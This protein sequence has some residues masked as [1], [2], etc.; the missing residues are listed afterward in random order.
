MTITIYSENMLPTD[1][2]EYELLTE[3]AEMAAGIVGMGCEI[4]LRRG[5]GSRMIMDSFIKKGEFKTHVMVD[6][7]GDIEYLTTEKNQT[8]LYTDYT[9]EMRAQCLQELFTYYDGKKPVNPIVFNM[10]DSEF[11]T[12]FYDYVPTYFNKGKVRETHYCIAHLDGPHDSTVV[13]EEAEF[14]ADRMHVGAMLVCDDT[15]LYDHVRAEKRILE[16]GFE[17]YKRG[18][19][20]AV[21]RKAAEPPEKIFALL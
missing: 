2:T 4:G 10:E 7:W 17:V 8:R 14:F 5:G 15:N 12:R 16:L 11:F 20:K 6:P 18:Q 13:I 21:Y 3:A 1:S 9:N 19:R